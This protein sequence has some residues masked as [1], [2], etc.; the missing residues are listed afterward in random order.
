MTIEEK[1]HEQCGIPSDIYQHLP[2]IK[3]YAQQCKTIC[4]FGVR[5]AVATWALLAARPEKLIS[6]DID[7]HPNILEVY[8]QTIKE[9]LVWEFVL[10]NDLTYDMPEVEM[11]MIDSLHT[12]TQLSNEL[13]IHGNKVSKYLLFHDTESFGVGKGEDAYE[14]VFHTGQN[15]G[16]GIWPAIEE[17]MAANPH[18]SIQQKFTNNNGLTVLRRS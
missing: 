14:S 3:G 16:R 4:E 17:F 12:Y 2:I 13:R 10:A 18:W 15:C 8:K 11:L 9:N 1:Y 5:S 6:V 7:W